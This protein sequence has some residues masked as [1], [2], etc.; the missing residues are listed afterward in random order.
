MSKKPITK[1]Q[2][3]ARRRSAKAR[4]CPACGR[5]AALSTRYILRDDLDIRTIGQA[6]TCLYCGH[7]VGIRNGEGFGR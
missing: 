5:Q 7:E 4:T 2:L 3:E 6:R 1:S